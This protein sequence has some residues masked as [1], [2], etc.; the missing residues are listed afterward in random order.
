M[1]IATYILVFVVS[2]Y[3]LSVSAQEADTLNLNLI[4]KETKIVESIGFDH[5]TYDQFKNNKAYDY[6]QFKQGSRSFY[7]IMTEVILNWWMK[8]VSSNITSKQVRIILW[9]IT[10]IVAGILLLIIF[11]YKP[12]LF[13]I[14]RR[15]EIDFT[16]EDEDIHAIDFD[17]L[18]KDS[19]NSGRFSD[20]IRWT[21]LLT[22]K[23]LHE[24]QH[25]SWDPFKTVIEYTYELKRTDLKPDFKNLSQQFLYYRYGNFDAT[26]DTYS[27][28][29]A[30]S[31]SITGR[32]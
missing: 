7:D 32:L 5:K 4:P 1:K 30:L 18:I 3:G 26:H 8:N 22:L 21:Y 9:V 25:I 17:E 2:F 15:N 14:N 6:Y 23:K 28:F 11:Y 12:S 31:N 24:R 20:A 19:L 13:Y 10:G 16:V 27:A 29:S